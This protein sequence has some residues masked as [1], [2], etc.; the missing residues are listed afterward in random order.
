MYVSLALQLNTE[1]IH[2]FEPQCPHLEDGFNNTPTPQGGLQE[3]AELTRT[4]HETQGLAG[5]NSGRV[6]N[7]VT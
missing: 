6:V 3:D 7:L 1:V 4:K 5:I 2:P